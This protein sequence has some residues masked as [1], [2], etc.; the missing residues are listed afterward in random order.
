MSLH[1]PRAERAIGLPCAPTTTRV[2]AEPRVRTA[3]ARRAR[4]GAQTPAMPQLDLDSNEAAVLKETLESAVSELGY[5]I[6]DTDAKDY[7]DKLKGKQAL[8]KAVLERL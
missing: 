7:R 8:L 5:E 4:H 6:A 1:V 3:P 2:L